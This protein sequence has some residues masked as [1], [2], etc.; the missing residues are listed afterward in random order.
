[1]EKDHSSLIAISSKKEPVLSLYTEEEMESVST[2]SSSAKGSST[3]AGQVNFSE[4]SSTSEE[5]HDTISSSNTSIFMNLY[6]EDIVD[7]RSGNVISTSASGSAAGEGMKPKLGL[8][9]LG[10]YA[11]S[12]NDTEEEAMNLRKAEEEKAKEL[13]KVSSEKNENSNIQDVSSEVIDDKSEPSNKVVEINVT[14]DCNETLTVDSKVP[15]PVLRKVEDGKDSDHHH[16][17]L[18]D[19]KFAKLERSVSKEEGQISAESDSNDSER[20]SLSGRGSINKKDTKRDKNRKK[21]KKKK[22]RKK[23]KQKY[24]QDKKESESEEEEKKERKK[25]RSR[26]REKSEKKRSFKQSRSKS[27]DRDSRRGRHSRSSS[28]DKIKRRRRSKERSKRSRSRSVDKRRSA[29]TRSS[30]FKSRSISPK[31]NTSPSKRRKDI[32]GRHSPSSRKRRESPLRRKKLSRSRSPRICRS[33]ERRRSRS[34]RKQTRSPTRKRRIT[35]NRSP[36]K[37]VSKIEGSPKRRRRKETPSPR[38]KSSHRTSSASDSL[39]SGHFTNIPLSKVNKPQEPLPNNQEPTSEKAAIKKQEPLV[40]TLPKPNDLVKQLSPAGSPAKSWDDEFDLVFT[41]RMSPRQ[42]KEKSMEDVLFGS[43]AKTPELKRPTQRE[44]EKNKPKESE[45]TEKKQKTQ[46]AKM[47]GI[48]SLADKETNVPQKLDNENGS[49]NSKSEPVLIPDEQCMSMSKDVKADVSTSKD[50]KYGDEDFTKH[51]KKAENKAEPVQTSNP[52]DKS[53][54]VQTKPESIPFLDET[55]YIPPT[56]QG[57]GVENTSTKS[58]LGISGSPSVGKGL[59]LTSAI[60]NNPNM[61]SG[62]DDHLPYPGSCHVI[63][64]DKTE[65]HKTRND[66]FGQPVPKKDNGRNSFSASPLDMEMSSPGG[67][68]IDQMNE[69]FWKQQQHSAS[70]TEFAEIQSR[71]AVVDSVVH[72]Q[73]SIDEPYEPESGLLVEDEFEEDLKFITDPKERKKR[74]KQQEKDK[75]KVQELIDRLHRQ[76]RVEEE[77]KHALKAYYKHRDISKEEY[78]SILRRAVPQVTNSSSAIDPERIRSLVK[79]YVAKIKG[80]RVESFD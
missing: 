35:P 43:E 65:M 58:L 47:A 61:G 37:T 77:V 5:I 7:S 22:K 42:G 23:R 79:K 59:V 1:M 29:T 8:L 21:D 76:A 50:A 71:Q 57:G 45:D 28:Q 72:E 19:E 69:E 31:R 13:A 60:H 68:V 66:G 20:S 9:L 36:S 25:I 32:K 80:Q 46:P 17:P 11:D 18:L 67:D 24:L 48:V 70:E 40:S 74:Q 12:G 73:S 52:D 33:S 10:E 30:N 63:N 38:R 78:K 27:K 54:F 26:S 15:S 51:T 56:L 16:T 3:G 2:T 4:V 75:T 44:S 49:S 39:D 6:E 41:E 64:V 62:G 55:P 14:S 34:P 53:A